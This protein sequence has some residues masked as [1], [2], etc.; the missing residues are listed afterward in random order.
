MTPPN[1][2]SGEPRKTLVE[3]FARHL[4][5]PECSAKHEALLSR[6]REA[7]EA[8]DEYRICSE[9]DGV[10]IRELVVECAALAERCKALEEFA[11]HPLVRA[12][13]IRLLEEP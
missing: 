2:P 4:E 6:L 12:R 1:A 11:E 8:L 9:A 3:M 7:D 13:V 5:H 10:R